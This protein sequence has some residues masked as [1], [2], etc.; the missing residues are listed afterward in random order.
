MAQRMQRTIAAALREHHD[1]QER[2]V[3]ATA[4]PGAQQLLELVGG[5]IEHVTAEVIARAARSGNTLARQHLTTT[6]RV[7][8]WAIAQL[9]TLLCPRRIVIGGGVSLMG[10]DLLLRPLADAVSRQV[11]R[12]FADCYDIVPGA[13][14][15]SVVLHGAL[16]LAQTATASA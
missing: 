4:R 15:E 13:L 1:G 10:D 11:F 8:G 5:K 16:R 3:W 6:H 2:T 7:L 14:G 12:P 9:I